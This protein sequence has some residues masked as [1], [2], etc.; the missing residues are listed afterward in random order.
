M[1]SIFNFA[2]SYAQ[3][4]QNQVVI[5]AGAHRYRSRAAFKLI[6]LN[7]KYNFLGSC[8]ALLDLCA[9]PGGWLQ[10]RLSSVGT[11]AAAAAAEQ[12]QQQSPKGHRS[13]VCCSM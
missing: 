4:C 9:A 13:L 7:R 6:Q 3:E 10:V 5:V 2:A 12:Q 11:A 8:R 1:A